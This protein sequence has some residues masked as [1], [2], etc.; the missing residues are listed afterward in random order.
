[1][2][3]PT[4][5]YVLLTDV[6]GSRQIGDRPQ[7][8][9][10]LEKA[11]Q[12]VQE[13]YAP[14]FAL[15]IRVWKGLDETAAILR[16]PWCL[17]GIMDQLHHDLAPRQVRF[18]VVRGP[19]DVW[20]DTDDVARADGAAF[21][22]AAAAMAALKKEGL[23]FRCET[24]NPS[25]DAAWKTQVNLLQLIKRDWT[26][27]QRRIY[28]LYNETGAQE[29]VAQALNITQQAVSKTLKGIA[30]AQISIL[31]KSLDNWTKTELTED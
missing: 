26:V 13:R 29:A 3:G 27:Q 7:F 28:R 18:V 22:Q 2:K 1:M 5:T 6:V 17:Y 16:Q 9:Q 30:A 4:E 23:L 21:H 25:F 19:V 10:Q 24:G 12:G 14:A 11:L 20:P 8:E 31:E 15:S